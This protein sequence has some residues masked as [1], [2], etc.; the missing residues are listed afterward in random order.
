MQI[1][2]LQLEVLLEE[3]RLV[4]VYHDVISDTVVEQFKAEAISQV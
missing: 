1:F 2:F 3:P 4:H